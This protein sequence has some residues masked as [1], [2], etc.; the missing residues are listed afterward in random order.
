[1]LVPRAGPGTPAT[2]RL[3]SPPLSP[4]RHIF[5]ACRQGTRRREST[6]PRSP[7]AVP[8]TYWAIRPRGIQQGWVPKLGKS[9]LL[10]LTCYL[11]G[12]LTAPSTA[13]TS[14]TIASA[15][16]EDL[17]ELHRAVSEWT[18]P[19]IP[20]YA[21][22]LATDAGLLPEG[23]GRNEALFVGAAVRVATEDILQAGARLTQANASRDE[24]VE[25]SLKFFQRVADR[26]AELTSGFEQICRAYYDF[27]LDVTR[28]ERTQAEASPGSIVGSLDESLALYIPP[29]TPGN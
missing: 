15:L 12:K 27:E 10:Q 13:G 16:R 3:N 4:E 5:D 20:V 19:E 8:E 1:M 2:C 29:S 11:G 18:S 6:W 7:H 25:T 21:N 23:S 22:R 26:L 17:A 14:V 9:Y 24:L 28:F